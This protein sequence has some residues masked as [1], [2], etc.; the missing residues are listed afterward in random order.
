[1]KTEMKVQVRAFHV[2]IR[3]ERTGEEMDDTIILEKAKLQ[4]GATVGLGDEDII[5]RLYNRQ[6]FRVLEINN[7]H[8]TTI[9]VD[10]SK[11]YNELVAEEYL[12]MEE[13]MASNEVST[14]G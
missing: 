11:A 13:Q 14:N 2:R 7:V 12:A 10:L 6:G 1:M 8:K 9:T 5:Y 4:A 3:D